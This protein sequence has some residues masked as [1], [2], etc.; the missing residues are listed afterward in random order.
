MRLNLPV[1]Q[2]NYD[3]PGDELLVSST[4]TKGEIT[5]CNPAFV[6]VSGYAYEELIGQ[7][8]NLIRH[9]DMPAALQGHVAH[10]CPW[11]SLDGTGQEPPQERRPLLGARQCHAHH[12][13]RQ[14]QRLSVGAYQAFGRKWPKPKRCTRACATRKSRH[15]PASACAQ[16]RCAVWA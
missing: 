5:H 16:A 8:H 9:P 2:Q 3:F 4:N 11:L 13:R 6:R 1:S 15:R 10:H 7:P 14:A 12:G